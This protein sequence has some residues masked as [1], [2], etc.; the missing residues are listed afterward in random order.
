VNVGIQSNV[1]ND[2]GLYLLTLS[3]VDPNSTSLNIDAS[4]DVAFVSPPSFSLNGSA[5]QVTAGATTNNTATVN[6]SP[7]NGFT[8]NVNLTC[9]VKYTFLAVNV[10]SCSLSPTS[11]SIA[12]TAAATS[13]VTVFT[14]ARTSA[15]LAPGPRPLR[16]GGLSVALAVLLWFCVPSR[17]RAWVWMVAITVSAISIGVL[18]CGSGGGRS[19]GT[20]GGGNNGTTPGNYSVTV[21]GTDAATGKV[22]AQTSITLT[23]N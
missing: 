6:V 2:P 1:A 17:R 5:I 10:P 4:T 19:G 12:G 20:G 15:S 18:G 21:T 23:V 8:G 11:V 9:A 14:T 22:T 16:L 3:A 13:T 7:A